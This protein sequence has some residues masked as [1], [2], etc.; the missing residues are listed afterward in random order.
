MQ[1]LNKNTSLCYEQR[2]RLDMLMVHPL[3]YCSASAPSLLKLESKI[4]QTFSGMHYNLDAMLK[5]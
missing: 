3:S 1:G 4:T 5:Q 2:L